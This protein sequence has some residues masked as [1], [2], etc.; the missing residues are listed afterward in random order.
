MICIT[1]VARILL[2]KKRITT[3]MGKNQTDRAK[4]QEK[5]RLSLAELVGRLLFSVFYYLY[6]YIA[7][8]VWALFATIIVALTGFFDRQGRIPHRMTRGLAKHYIDVNPFWQRQFSLETELDA[9][10]TYVFVANHQSL[11]DVLVL[12]SIQANYKWVARQ[13]IFKV[14]GIGWLMRLSRYLSISHGDLKS[15]RRM[16]RRAGAWLRQGTSI[17]MF[18]EGARSFDGN[19]MPFKEGPFRLAVDS[20][21]AVVPVVIDGTSEILPRGALLINPFVS[22]KVVILEPIHPEQVEYDARALRDLVESRMGSALFAIRQQAAL[23]DITSGAPP[24]VAGQVVIP[25]DYRGDV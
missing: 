4:N 8:G 15:V 9:G 25:R 6:F 7:A 18:P 14:F 12:G 17:F 23:A 19:I 10:T 22:I 1:F 16:M 13:A 21:V 2:N 20:K 5:Q 11:A 24:A 3:E